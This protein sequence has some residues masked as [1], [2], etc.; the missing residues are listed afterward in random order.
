MLTSPI[1]IERYVN[2]RKH[3]GTATKVNIYHNIFFHVYNHN[4]DN[5]YNNKHL[6]IYKFF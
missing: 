1:N 5:S 3:L 6:R 2:I 4:N